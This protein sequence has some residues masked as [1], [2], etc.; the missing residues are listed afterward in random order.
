MKHKNILTR[1]EADQIYERLKKTA[2]P[3]EKLKEYVHNTLLRNAHY[4]WQY[5]QGNKRFGYC[6]FCKKDFPLE[7]DEEVLNAKHNDTVICPCCD[8]EVTKR[9]AGI[10][11]PNVFANAA[12]FKVDETGALVVYVYCFT[13]DYKH[14]FHIDTPHFNCFNIGYFDL[15][16]YF[17]LL[18]G[19]GTHPYLE[20]RYT[21]EMRFADSKTVQYPLYFYQ[22]KYEGIKCF[23]LEEAL[24]NSN[25]R[26][27]CLMDFMQ[28]D[29]AVDMFRYLKMYCSYPELTEKL[30]KEGFSNILISYVQ[31]GMKGLLNF[32]GQTV[33]EI[34]RVDK[35]HL[36]FLKAQKTSITGKY[37]YSDI[38]A[39]QFMQKN[40]LKLEKDTFNFLRNHNYYLDLIILL[41]QFAGIK[42][43][44]TYAENQGRL[45]ACRYSYGSYEYQF[46]QNYRDYIKQCKQLGYDLTDK[47]IAMP[48]NLFQSHQQLT[49][50]LERRRIEEQ[51][52]K[53]R[54]AVKTKAEKEKKFAKRLSKLKEKY[55]FT[56]GEFL[57]RPA[58]GYED[59]C[60]E[61]TALHHCVY[62][63][64][65]DEYIAGKTDILFI[66]RTSAPDKPFYTVEYLYGQVIQ[67]RTLHNKSATPE[68]KAFLEKWQNYLKSKNIKQKEVA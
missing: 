65:A 18:H 5:K 9:Y 45:C 58:T 3:S 36:N 47:N 6:T 35:Q 32:R 11:R 52:R 2:V 14:N 42:K 37:Q 39:I 60:A 44:H 50:L 22:C 34:L 10:S 20:D 53:N 66:R 4:L 23:G 27:S 59:L 56:D 54:E 57:I 64:Y 1:E 19:W 21:G 46:F 48:A 55:D 41:L 68:I 43:V 24:K 29:Q 38:E 67:C 26:Y 17:H 8:K 62:T 7:I 16:K 31:G 40:K 15:H 49:E 30:M 51:A 61:A 25:L 33:N 13:Y 12:E 28:K 63:N